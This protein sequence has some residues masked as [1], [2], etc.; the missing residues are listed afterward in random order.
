MAGYK[1]IFL[2]LT[3]NAIKFSRVFERSLPV[4]RQPEE[5]LCDYYGRLKYWQ[6]ID[7]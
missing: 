5:V 6:V 1:E 3:Q 4:N 2:S 7:G